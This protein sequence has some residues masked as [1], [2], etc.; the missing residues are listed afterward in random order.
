M[1]EYVVS[2]LGPKVIQLS[3][4]MT[5]KICDYIRPQNYVHCEEYKTTW[6]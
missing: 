4:R 6:V 3:S 1:G 5:S 2:T